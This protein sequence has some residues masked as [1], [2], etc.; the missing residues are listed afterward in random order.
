MKTMLACVAVLSC[1]VAAWLAVRAEAGTRVAS[2][3]STSADV[4]RAH[5]IEVP[6]AWFEAG[7]GAR[8]AV[9][10]FD[11][12]A[13]GVV[14]QQVVRRETGITMHGVVDEGA[15]GTFTLTLENGQIAGGF[16]TDIGAFGLTP[17]AGGVGTRTSGSARSAAGWVECRAEQLRPEGVARCLMREGAPPLPGGAKAEDFAPRRGGAVTHGPAAGVAASG[18]APGAGSGLTRGA[19]PCGCADDQSIIDVLCVYTTPAKNAAGGAAAI[20]TRFQNALDAANGAFTNS[21][22][23]SGG[24]NRLQLRAAG[25]AEVSYDEAAPDWLNHLER[26]TD[27]DD[28]FMDNVHA[29]RDQFKA[30]TVMLVVNDERFTGGAGWWAIWDQSQAFTTANWRGL[31]GGSLLA[32][33]E[34]G[35]NFGCAHDHEHDVS[36]P[37]SYAWGHYFTFAG[38]TYGD[39][40]SYVG[41][42]ALQQYSNPELIHPA[43]GQP[44]GV[45]AGEPR[46]AFNAL[47]IRQTRWTLANYRDAVRI[48]DCNGNGVDD[49]ADI[50]AGRSQDANGDCRPDDCE[51]RRYVDA[52]RA[53]IGEGTSWSTSAADLGEIL[54]VAGLRCSNIS[55]LWAAD[56]TYKPDSGT[57]DRYRT[58]TLRDGLG[59]YGGFQGRSRAG[60]G[61]MLLSQRDPAVHLST[62]SGEIG[63]SATAT[64]NS[65]SVVYAPGAGTTAVIDGFTIRDGYSDDSGA[66]IYIDAGSPTIV[67]CTITNNR[68][69]GGAGLVAWNP[70]QGATTLRDCV[71]EGN[72]AAGGGGGAVGVYLKGSRLEAERCFFRDNTAAWGGAVSS[73]DSVV[74][75]T[76]CVLS[77]NQSTAQNGGAIDVNNTDLHLVNSVVVNNRSAADGGGVWIAGSTGS[78]VVNSTIAGNTAAFT[79]GLTVYFATAHVANSILW[80]NTGHQPA[81]QE[82]Q[83]TYFSGSGEVRYSRVQGWTGSLGGPGNSGADPLLSESVAGD[84]S[85]LAGSSAI[86][87]AEGIA[88]AAGVVEDVYGAARRIDDPLTADGGAAGSPPLDIGAAEYQPGAACPADLNG[89]GI[90]DFAD[91]LEFLNLYDGQ[92]L[93]VDFNQDGLVDFGDYL[94][95][96]NLYDEG[97]EGK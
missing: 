78:T 57:G 15:S 21:G 31:G 87:A 14:V 51:E 72:T 27:P 97:C 2:S 76:S 39:I 61:E 89:D 28:G 45:H 1:G 49:A 24:V 74:R 46:A 17:A 44:V 95:F 75:L 37:L 38:Q 12:V 10:L 43:S 30:D 7:E 6:R 48:V 84:V 79:G 16:W 53:G 94:E 22:I 33:H 32:A 90:V 62:L 8:L 13:I 34:I 40:M 58:V 80:G 56:G 63:G 4:L 42:V 59:L 81:M 83:I 68:A 50:A 41:D 71:F 64:D 52:S 85:L 96:L 77:G 82:N 36:A 5:A 26:V 35:H 25:Y 67:N 3:A 69:W 9:A 73:T 23:N 29:L 55:Q 20:Q 65:Y 86:D 19:E 91:Y 93:R 70:G 54:S 11:D 47:V 60:G 92:D 18:A 66:G 88:L